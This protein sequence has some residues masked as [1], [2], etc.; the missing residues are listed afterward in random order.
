MDALDFVYTIKPVIFVPLFKAAS[1]H[2]HGTIGC[3]R[4]RKERGQE[5]L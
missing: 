2:G 1:C 5:L 4:S 3:N